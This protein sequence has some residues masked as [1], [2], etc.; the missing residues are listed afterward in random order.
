M[1]S[2]LQP[3]SSST[4]NFRPIFEQALEEYEKKTGN[5]LTAHPLAAEINGCTSP[6]AILT[7]LKRKAIELEKSGSSDERLSNWLIPATTAL[8]AISVTLDEGVG[9]VSYHRTAA[10]LP[11][12]ILTLNF[13][14]Y[15]LPRSSFL[16]SV[17]S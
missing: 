10:S 12:F 3:S 13:R 7:V 15:P 17:F 2:T 5:D 14:Y 6:N 9:L 1:S 4:L 8:H 11:V 16:R